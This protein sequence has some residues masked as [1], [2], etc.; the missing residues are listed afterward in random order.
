MGGAPAYGNGGEGRIRAVNRHSL[1][2]P[3]PEPGRRAA[4]PEPCPTICWTMFRHPW[5]TPP[6]TE[7]KRDDRS[8]RAPVQASKEPRTSAHSPG[9]SGAAADRRIDPKAMSISAAGLPP[10]HHPTPGA[11]ACATA[12]PCPPGPASV[13]R[14]R[15]S[16]D[17]R[18]RSCRYRVSYRIAA[19]P[20]SRPRAV[21]GALRM[22]GDEW[23][24][25]STRGAR[26]I[27]LRETRAAF[28]AQMR[29]SG[30]RAARRSPHAGRSPRARDRRAPA[31]SQPPSSPSPGRCGRTMRGSAPRPRSPPQHVPSAAELPLR[32]LHPA[33]C[34]FAEAALGFARHRPYRSIVSGSRVICTPPSSVAAGL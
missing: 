18:A 16:V 15:A 5:A 6:V 12:C 21:S 14:G 34:R 27:I 22:K 3:L 10:F 11:A 23:H 25:R 32:R 19:P 1:N 24:Q 33:M 13:R 4:Q 8:R 26:S 29:R 28:A 17:E 30:A 9:N 20:S 31:G 2:H 7:K